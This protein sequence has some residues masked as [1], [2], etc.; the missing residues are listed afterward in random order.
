MHE[1]RWLELRE[2]LWMMFFAGFGIG[3]L[4]VNVV[5]YLTAAY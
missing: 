2:F 3:V 1:K 4:T 5:N